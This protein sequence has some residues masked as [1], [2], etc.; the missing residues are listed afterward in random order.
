MKATVRRLAAAVT[1]G[2]MLFAVFAP[3]ALADHD[4]NSNTADYWEAHYTEHSAVCFKHT[5]DSAHGDVVNAEGGHGEAVK[6][7]PFQQEWPGDH[8]EA[9]IVKAGS[10]GGDDG[11][12]NEIYFHPSAG[13]KYNAPIG[14][15][16]KVK[17]VSHW[18]VCKGT[19]PQT[20]TTTTQPEET[21]TTT[22]VDTTTTTE[23]TTTT[24]APSTTT[25][26]IA[27]T[28]TTQGETTTTPPEETTTTT[29]QPEET[30]TTTVVTTTT[31]PETT[32][33][34]QPETTT[35]DPE[36]TT[37]TVVVT[38]TAPPTTT[39]TEGDGVLPFT[40]ADIGPLSW[41][42]GVGLALGTLLIVASRKKEDQLEG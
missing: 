23:A 27:T 4:G 34:T 38:T 17:D 35:T 16:G 3:M 20:T 9:L 24:T 11:Q 14:G 30:T 19:I 31:Q 2:G 18:I 1:F 33:T 22:I 37:T 6:L 36:T 8:W 15:N 40:G 39:T 41:V 12:G 10:S 28:T 29:T 26:T 42:A 25:T 7:N 5:G 21:T 32:T 13:V